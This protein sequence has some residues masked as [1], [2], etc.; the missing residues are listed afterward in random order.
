MDKYFQFLLEFVGLFFSS[1]HVFWES[2]RR[3]SIL[4][5]IV[6]LPVTKRKAQWR[7]VCVSVDV[8][9]VMGDSLGGLVGCWIAIC[10][11]S[12][13]VSRLFFWGWGR[14]QWSSR[15]I[16]PALGAWNGPL[17]SPRM[18]VESGAT[19]W[20]N[21]VGTRGVWFVRICIVK[22]WFYI[23]LSHT[24]SDVHGRW[25]FFEGDTIKL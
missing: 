7:Q 5:V 16:D 18:A 24:N 3:W 8:A 25:T 17:G 12:H 2:S 19:A 23:K 22:I 4:L 9:E 20:G 11:L 14:R 21:W 15:R 1:K 6:R 10:N 13:R